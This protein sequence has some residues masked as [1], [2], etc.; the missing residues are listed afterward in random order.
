[1]KCA[2]GSLELNDHFNPLHAYMLEERA[3]IVNTKEFNI[4]LKE[5]R[6]IIHNLPIIQ[7]IQ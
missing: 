5:T 3:R 4:N 6:A 1:M 7:R 2:E